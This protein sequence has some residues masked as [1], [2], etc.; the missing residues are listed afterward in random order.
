MVW[1][2]TATAAGAGER[3]RQLFV[4]FGEQFGLGTFVAEGLVDGLQLAAEGRVVG[5][6]FDHPTRRGVV[7]RCR[8]IVVHFDQPACGRARVALPSQRSSP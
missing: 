4:R 3:S 5:L 6:N 8:G 7:G 1:A 2:G